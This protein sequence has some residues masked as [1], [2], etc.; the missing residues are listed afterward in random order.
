MENQQGL[1]RE[2]FTALDHLQVVT[3]GNLMQECTSTK[4]IN[5]PVLEAGKCELGKQL[6]RYNPEQQCP[7]PILQ[8]KSRI[9]GIEVIDETVILAK[10]QEI[11]KVMRKWAEDPRDCKYLMDCLM[12]IK[13]EYFPTMKKNLNVNMDIQVKDQFMKFY[14]EVKY[15]EATNTNQ[16]GRPI[17]AKQVID[18]PRQECAGSDKQD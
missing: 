15:N 5:C 12:K 14:D 16:A 6:P 1:L 17:D 7:F 11:Y 13:E 2:G 9:Y 8:A 3:L 10:L 4:C 18:S